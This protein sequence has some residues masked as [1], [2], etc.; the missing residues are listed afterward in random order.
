M[1]T[2]NQDEK[3][4]RKFNKYISKIKKINNIY[5][6]DKL[7]LYAYYK[8]AL[9]GDNDKEQPSMLN[10]VETEKWKA[11]N[12]VKHTSKEDS[13]KFYINKMV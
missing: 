5:N 13:M 12:N 7:Y 8:Q 2:E 6:N 3:L 9:F 10:R 4:V 1:D 11:W